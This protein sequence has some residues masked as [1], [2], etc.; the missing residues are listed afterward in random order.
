MARDLNKV[1]LTHV[2][3]SPALR[4]IQTAAAILSGQSLGQLLLNALGQFCGLFTEFD[5]EK[6]LA[7]TSDRENKERAA[8]EKLEH[9]RQE[10]AAHQLWRHCASVSRPRT[11]RASAPRVAR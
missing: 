10:A 6:Q 5:K 1:Q 4:C 3:A 2:F 7:S 8:R 11:A 9:D